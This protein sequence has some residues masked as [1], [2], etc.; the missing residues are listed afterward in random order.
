MGRSACDSSR[1]GHDSAIAQ[2]ES[3]KAHEQALESAIQ[4]AIAQLRVAE[5]MLVSARAQVEQKDAGLKQAQVDL[6][7]T[8][9]RAP[10][11]GVVVSR[12]SEERRVGKEWRHRWPP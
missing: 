11:Q 1:A 4:S 9:I 7:H 3:P 12:R 6:D 8:T 10:V 5:A 2:V